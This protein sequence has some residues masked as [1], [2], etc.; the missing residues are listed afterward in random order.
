M[1]GTRKDRRRVDPA[2]LHR[3]RFW[4]CS[5]K[6]RHGFMGYVSPTPPFPV[7]G[8]QS[9]DSQVGFRVP[10]CGAVVPDR[11]APG[12]CIPE[13]GRF[14]GFVTA[15]RRDALTMTRWPAGPALAGLVQC[16]RG[17]LASMGPGLQG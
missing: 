9:P 13:E 8:R 3:P 5:D 7:W 15:S 4:V 1:A 14:G 17:D 2:Q 16:G 6:A 12:I 11:C 10:C